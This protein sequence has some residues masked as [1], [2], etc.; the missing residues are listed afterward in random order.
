MSQA[1]VYA[2]GTRLNAVI[3]HSDP[4]LGLSQYPRSWHSHHVVML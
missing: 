3:F 2:F 4:D 1:F